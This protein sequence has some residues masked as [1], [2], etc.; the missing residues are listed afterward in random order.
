MDV[1]ETADP[2]TNKQRTLTKTLKAVHNLKFGVNALCTYSV[3]WGTHR[4]ERRSYDSGQTVVVHPEF[5]VEGQ[6][7]T[8]HIL[9]DFR[10][11]LFHPT[12]H[13]GWLW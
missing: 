4:S 8:S 10:P 3:I 1:P 13:P 11:L 6:N 12:E 9:R 2:R 5:Q 7:L